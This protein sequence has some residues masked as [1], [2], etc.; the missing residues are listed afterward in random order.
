M[1]ISVLKVFLNEINFTLFIWQKQIIRQS[2]IDE[3]VNDVPE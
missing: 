2:M 1:S 3:V